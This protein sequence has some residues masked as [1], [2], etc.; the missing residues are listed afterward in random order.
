MRIV[1]VTAV[2]GDVTMCLSLLVVIVGGGG[3]VGGVMEGVCLWGEVVGFRCVCWEAVGA[4]A[5]RASG[6]E[7]F[8]VQR[9]T[10]N[11]WLVYSFVCVCGLA[12][13]ARHTCRCRVSRLTPARGWYAPIIPPPWWLAFLSI[14]CDGRRPLLAISFTLAHP[15]TVV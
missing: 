10:T 8:R 6:M 4:L 12:M 11:D 9:R 15:T 7:V 14:S 2:I 5:P 1:I 3:V 13:H